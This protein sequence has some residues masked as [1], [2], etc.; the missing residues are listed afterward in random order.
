[1]RFSIRAL[2]IWTSVVG[3]SLASLDM[4]RRTAPLAE[5]GSRIGEI[6]RRI[7][8]PSQDALTVARIENPQSSS[9]YEVQSSCRLIKLI[10]VEGGVETCVGEIPVDSSVPFQV[11]VLTTVAQ[12]D[13]QQFSF[14]V[15]WSRGKRKLGE[16]NS[17]IRLTGKYSYRSYTP[18]SHYQRG[19]RGELLTLQH[20]G[21]ERLQVPTLNYAAY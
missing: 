11:N 19:G 17:T 5:L 8:G 1:M 2:L 18:G 12:E 3:L 9:W 6:E 7:I 16:F 21:Q 14:N 20:L 4:R 13:P 10:V 15:F